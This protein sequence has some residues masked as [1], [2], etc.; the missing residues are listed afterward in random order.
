MQQLT[1]ACYAHNHT[2]IAATVV[3][4]AQLQG[5]K[6]AHGLEGS[7]L[8]PV[9]APTDVRDCTWRSNAHGNA[10]NGLIPLCDAPRHAAS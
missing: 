5:G 10:S 1:A 9:A 4:E 3:I 6:F 8:L 7:V 2:I